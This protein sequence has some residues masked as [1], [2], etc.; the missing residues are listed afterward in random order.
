[1]SRTLGSFREESTTAANIACIRATK[2][3]YH[4]THG[5]QTRL[6]K[7]KN[8]AN[9][10]REK[11]NPEQ[12]RDGPRQ[13]ERGGLAL[14]QLPDSPHRHSHHRDLPNRGDDCEGGD[15]ERSPDQQ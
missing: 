8:R 14:V 9:L 11:E 4:G 6:S 7:V 12:G 3:P 1:M 10:D 15:A 5:P 13:L 2:L